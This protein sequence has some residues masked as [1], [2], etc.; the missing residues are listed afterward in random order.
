MKI[1]GI[2][3]KKTKAGQV[4]YEVKWENYEKTTWEPS[5]NIPTFITN[6]YERTGKNNIP[7]A[8]IKHTKVVGM[9]SV[10]NASLLGPG[11]LTQSTVQY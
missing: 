7:A 9:C 2:L 3:N 11:A 6:Y 4:F 10:K 8:R 5:S 1:I